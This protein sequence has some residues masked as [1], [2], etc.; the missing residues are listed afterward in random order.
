M[1]KFAYFF[2]LIASLTLTAC[3]VS[4]NRFQLEGRFL[5]MDQGEFYVYS[6]DGGIEGVDTIKVIDGRFTYEAP[7]KDK[8]TLMIVFP[9]FSEQ[10]VFAEPGK[11]VDIKADASH[12]KELTVKGSKDKIGRAHV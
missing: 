3:G 8:F 9:N 4:S 1:K 12:L 2:I 10:P 11:S 7:C 6:P 5:H